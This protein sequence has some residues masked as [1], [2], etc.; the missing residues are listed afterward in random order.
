MNQRYYS[1]ASL[2]AR[3]RAFET[4]YGLSTEEVV[5]AYHAGSRPTA[6][7]GFDTFEW[8]ATNAE[9]ARLC[10]ERQPQPA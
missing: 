9:L 10:G 1:T 4:R 8:A 6:V 7:S 5:A 3:L 2:R